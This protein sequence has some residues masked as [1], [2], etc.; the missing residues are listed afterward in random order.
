M[1]PEGRGP[2]MVGRRE[3][4]PAAP[5]SGEPVA[6]KLR[7]IAEKARKEPSFR[8]TSLYHLMNEEHLRGCFQRLRN[9]AAAGIDSVTKSGSICSNAPRRRLCE[10]PCA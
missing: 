10:E 1:P 8:F 9:N 3:E 7:R 2:H 4:T 5:S 6:T